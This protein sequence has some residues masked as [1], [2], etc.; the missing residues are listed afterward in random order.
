MIADK[1]RSIV[2]E[3]TEE[4]LKVYPNSVGVL[5]NNPP[6][7]R[8]LAYLAEF[9]YLSPLEPEPVGIDLSDYSRGMGAVGLPGDWSSPSRFVRAAFLRKYGQGDGF[10]QFFHLLGGVEQPRG[11]V[12]LQD[13]RT[14]VSVYTSCCDLARGV[15][16]YTTY[17]NRQITGVDIYGENLDGSALVCYPLREKENIRMEN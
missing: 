17:E 16:Y 2:V 10:S 9:E 4:G 7:P 3:A 8:Q 12:C 14:V 1:D 6:F 15:Y 5:T 13:G 11:G